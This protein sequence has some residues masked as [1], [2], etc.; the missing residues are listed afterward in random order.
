MFGRVSLTP[1]AIQKTA[2]LTQPEVSKLIREVRELT[3]LTQVQL[4]GVLGVA[5]GT[6]NRWENGH[7]QPSPLALKQIKALLEE[8]HDSPTIDL[9]ERSQ[10]LLDQYFPQP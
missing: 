9:Q 1:T 10:K 7:M 6:I 8:I 2:A 5:Y 3:A 4:A